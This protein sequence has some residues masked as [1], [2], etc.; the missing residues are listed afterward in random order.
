MGATERR[1]EG[2]RT[3]GLEIGWQPE[4]LTGRSRIVYTYNDCAPVLIQC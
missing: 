1:G 4:I 3:G 2:G